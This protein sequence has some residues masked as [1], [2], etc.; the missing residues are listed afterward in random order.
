ME[1]R[2]N[3]AVGVVDDGDD[4]QIVSFQRAREPPL[5]KALPAG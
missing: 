1:A 2:V 5:Q 3:E 4:L